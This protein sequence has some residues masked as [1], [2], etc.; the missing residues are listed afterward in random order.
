[1]ISNSLHGYS[2]QFRSGPVDLKAL[3]LNVEI[4]SVSNEYSKLITLY[5]CDGTHMT[6]Q[7]LWQGFEEITS[8]E[9]L[10]TQNS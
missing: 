2:H 8:V 7:Q 6:T 9:E 5:V 4:F 1:M 10:Q 3:A